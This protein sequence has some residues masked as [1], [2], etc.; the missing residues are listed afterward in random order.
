MIRLATLFHQLC[1]SNNRRAQPKMEVCCVCFDSFHTS[2]LIRLGCQHVY[3]GGCLT[4]MFV[5]SSKDESEFPPR[6]CKHEIPLEHVHGFITQQ[7][8]E[9]FEHA[10]EEF[11]T[12]HLKRVYC[13]NPEC[14]KFMSIK[15]GT[16][17][18]C[19]RCNTYTCRTC[20]SAHSPKDECP[21]T[22]PDLELATL[23]QLR[24]WRKCTGCGIFVERDRGCAHIV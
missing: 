14:A 10:S 1:F 21:G 9:N 19:T 7:E 5:R 2:Q 22:V 11:S 18:K 24:D 15:E 8:R 13:Q 20:K 6:C 3:C 23:A 16:I 17:A 4:T 12:P